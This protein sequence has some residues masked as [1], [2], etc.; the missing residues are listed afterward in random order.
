MAVDRMPRQQQQQRSNGAPGQKTQLIVGNLDWK[1]T[2][3]DIK[4][5]VARRRIAIGVCIV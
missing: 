1:V 3:Q 4:V 2:D 5:S